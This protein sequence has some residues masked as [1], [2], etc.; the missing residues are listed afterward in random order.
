MDRTMR[1]SDISLPSLNPCLK[2]APCGMMRRDDEP[3][4][5]GHKRCSYAAAITEQTMRDHDMYPAT[6]MSI[7]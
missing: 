4:V 5:S 6:P 7:C 1:G 3:D 2:M